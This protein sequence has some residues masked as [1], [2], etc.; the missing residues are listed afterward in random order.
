MQLARLWL[1]HRDWADNFHTFLFCTISM[2]REEKRSFAYR[3]ALLIL[4]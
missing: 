2:I 3:D 4:E 1:L